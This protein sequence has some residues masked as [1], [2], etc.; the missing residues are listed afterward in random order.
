[1]LSGRFDFAQIM[2]HLPWSVFHQCVARYDGKIRQGIHV[3]R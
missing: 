3:F 1:M 2:E